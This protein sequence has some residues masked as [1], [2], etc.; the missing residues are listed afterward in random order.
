MLRELAEHV[1]IPTGKGF[2]PGLN[3]YRDLLISRLERLTPT[4]DR[5]PGTPRP[6][7]IDF[8]PR[9]RTAQ[10]PITIVARH[11]TGAVLPRLLLAGHIDTVHDPDG[12][13][14]SLTI[15]PDGQTARGPGAADMKG[16]ILIAVHALEALHRCGAALNW[17][18]LLN[19]DEE[20][21]SFHS[22]PALVAE[23]KRHDFGLAL[24]PALPGGALAVERMGS[25]QFRIEVFGRSAHVGRDFASG[26]SAVTRLGEIIAE[27]G[28]WPRPV[29]GVIIN[30]GPLKGGGVTNAV[31]D[32]AACW[33]NV[34]FADEPAA[35]ELETKLVALAT[36][37]E[38][39]PRV[40]VHHRWNRPAKPLTPGTQRLADAARRA[41]ESLGQSLPFSK[42]GGVCDGNI[43][44]HAGLPT[45]DTLGVR[46]G[47]LH[48]TD[49]W[50]E[51]PSLVERSQLLAVLMLQLSGL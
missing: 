11:Q 6:A 48:T 43:L 22:D 9:P 25:G 4:I 42:T 10:P 23:A 18:F 36:T 51:V 32:Y 37:A 13:F 29:E 41:A 14:N 2:E 40:V 39:M 21:G 17:S 24:E 45:I 46:G 38:A 44:Q 12:P 47:G 5:I 15:A 20:T 3:Q 34:R 8:S 19:S 30:V 27:I 7:W 1:A 16:G 35:A 33:G 50:I 49:E 26:V 31:A 28:T